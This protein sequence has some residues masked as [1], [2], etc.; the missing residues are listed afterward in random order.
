MERA[1]IATSP[2][3]SLRSVSF[4]LFTLILEIAAGIVL[5]QSI[6]WAITHLKDWPPT[7]LIVFSG[8]HPIMAKVIFY[9]LFYTPNFHLTRGNEYYVTCND[10][11]R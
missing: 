6:W 3:V 2:P 8:R 7:W 10:N 1:G 4:K 5:G 11:T 9:G